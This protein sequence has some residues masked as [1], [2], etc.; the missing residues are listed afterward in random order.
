MKLIQNR[1]GPPE[2]VGDGLRVQNPFV[3]QFSGDADE[4]MPGVIE[5]VGAV[6]DGSV[7]CTELRLMQIEG[8]P[9]V[10]ADWLR[11]FSFPW[12]MDLARTFASTK[13]DSA[14]AWSMPADPATQQ[15]AMA[16]L[17]PRKHHRLTPEFLAKVADSYK[18]N[19]SG[20]P[21]KAVAEEMSVS[22][23]TAATWVGLCRSDEYGLLP[24][25]EDNRGKG[26]R[27]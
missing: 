9:P 25:V 13:V 20:W 23:S 10:E 11:A 16:A 8:G 1:S 22:R 2:N 18:A 12:F 5:V 19:E 3:V 27:S 26:K 4:Q 17:R 15:A 14:G 7:V 24:K 6:D 21:T